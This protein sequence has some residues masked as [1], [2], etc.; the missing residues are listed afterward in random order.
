M[1]PH[2]LASFST[3]FLFQ[4]LERDIRDFLLLSKPFSDRIRDSAGR[5][6]NAA[7][8]LGWPGYTCTALLV[9]VLVVGVTNTFLSLGIVS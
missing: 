6:P 8:P 1:T 4:G 5:R 9:A 2:H 3:L 7:I